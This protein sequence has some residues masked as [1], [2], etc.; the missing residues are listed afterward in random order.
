MANVTGAITNVVNVLCHSQ[1]CPLANEGNVTTASTDIMAAVQAKVNAT[2]RYI[3]V[4]HAVPAKFNMNQVP[5]SPAATPSARS[6]ANI[7]ADYFSMNVFSKA[8]VAMD[9]RDALLTSVPSSPH[10]VVAPSSITV[11][12]LERFIPPSSRTEYMDLFSSD[13]PSVLV[14]RLVEL[15]PDGGSLLFIYPTA[16]GGNAFASRYLGPLLDPLLR[17]LVGI[18]GLSADVGASIGKMYAVDSM[19]PFEAMARKIN[20]LLR[21]LGRGTSSV[22]HPPPK[23]TVVQSSKQIVDLGRSVWMEWWVHQ[24]AGRIRAAMDTY[25]Q[26]GRRLPTN[27]DMTAGGLSRE[28]LDGVKTR[29]YAEYDEARDGVEVGVFIIKRTG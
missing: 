17:T 7:P 6:S 21:K 24:E 11:S 19:L 12:L 9:H 18:H 4:T 15:S 13:A 1:P 25:F 20:L 16:S 10:P 2:G 27:R 8:V 14:D 22:H 5:S 23:L 28:I 3:E 26:R 29:T